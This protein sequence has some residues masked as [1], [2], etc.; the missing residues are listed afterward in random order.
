MILASQSPRRRQLLEEAGFALVV[1]PADVDE[2][3]L[4]GEAPDELVARL[5]R[6]KAEAV[7][8][9]LA[10]EAAATPSDTCVPGLEDGL[11]VAADTIVWL[12]D[13]TALGKPA[14]A[15]D[16]C[17]MLGLLGGRTHHVSTGVCLL[18]LGPH[19][20]PLGARPFVE[21]TEVEFHELSPA[22]IR[23]YVA[24]GEPLDK[25]GAYGI[26]GEGRLLVRAIRGNYDNVV[27]LPVARLV[28]E[29]AALTGDP[30]LLPTLLERKH[31]A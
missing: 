5:S 4:P 31:H 8:A 2:T 13:G 22:D 18:H 27:G 6:A 17:R 23:A 7:R 14:D 28:R 25:A 29:A 26:Q 30:D 12:A 20:E 1:R 3:P 19:A 24:G 11:L 10:A 15:A 16:A 21:T 9:A